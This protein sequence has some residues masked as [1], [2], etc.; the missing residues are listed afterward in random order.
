MR[1]PTSLHESRAYGPE[2]FWSPVQKTFATIS[3][4]C[5]HEP[6]QLCP[7]PAEA[8]VP[9]AFVVKMLSPIGAANEEPPLPS[10]GL[11]LVPQNIRRLARR[12]TRCTTLPHQS[13]SV[14]NT[15]IKSAQRGEEFVYLRLRRADLTGYITLTLEIYVG[16]NRT[17]HLNKNGPAF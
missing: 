3:A 1:S 16:K 13:I 11:P 14:Y 15:R 10:C 5:C 17:V 8:D 12:R 2:N 7:Q 4:H 9:T 6:A